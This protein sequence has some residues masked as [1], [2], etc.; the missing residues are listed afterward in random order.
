VG[1]PFSPI[2]GRVIESGVSNKAAAEH[3]LVLDGTDGRVHHFDMG[4]AN[5]L[6]PLIEGMIVRVSPVEHA[7]F[8]QEPA[9]RPGLEVE[10][11]SHQPLE[12]LLSAD[13]PT[14]LD[15]ELISDKPE[16]LRDSGFGGAVRSALNK[17]REW[18]EAEQLISHN[19]GGYPADRIGVLRR[20]ELL[21]VAADL[22]HEVGIPYPELVRGA[23]A[24][25]TVARSRG[26]EIG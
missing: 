24:R 6:E 14:W 13:G 12:R 25:W 3:Y 7:A 2:V 21:R 17:R 8:Q 19:D 1:A 16:P 23:G 15:K 11:L 22:L 4:P 26:L 9:E 20:R 18:L 10:I 5:A